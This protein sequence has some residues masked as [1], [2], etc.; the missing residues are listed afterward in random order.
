M[1]IQVR[2]RDFTNYPLT[3]HHQGSYEPLHLKQF[4]VAPGFQKAVEVAIGRGKSN[5]VVDSDG[6]HVDM[7]KA[8]PLRCAEVLTEMWRTIGRTKKRPV[9]MEPQ[10]PF[11]A[12]SKW[13]SRGARK[14]PLA[15][16]TLTCEEGTVNGGVVRDK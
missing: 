12:R 15:V 4:D 9:R 5:K 8:A 10:N 7:F 3:A 16:R 2:P 14:I 11:P 6:L 1:E 13:R